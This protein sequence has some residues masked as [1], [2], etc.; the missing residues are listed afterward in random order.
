MVPIKVG[1]SGQ[2]PNIKTP[3]PIAPS[4]DVYLNGETNPISPVR[5]AITLN[6][7][8]IRTATAAPM[9]SNHA[10]SLMALHS[11]PII[12][13]PAKIELPTAV[14]RTTVMVGTSLVSFRVTIS[15]T[16]IKI[17]AAKATSE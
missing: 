5:I 6:I 16:V 12:I 14:E 15:R 8:A 10:V 3:N 1:P 13:I 4:I 11:T 9:R 2:S 17:I 7:V